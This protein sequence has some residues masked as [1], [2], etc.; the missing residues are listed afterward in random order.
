[1]IF[2]SSAEL[3]ARPKLSF[4]CIHIET[5]GEVSVMVLRAV[6]VVETNWFSIPVDL[7]TLFHI[8]T[9]SISLNKHVIFISLLCRPE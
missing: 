5:Y 3:S 7:A 6:F 8:P 2:R 1:M 9:A 4:C